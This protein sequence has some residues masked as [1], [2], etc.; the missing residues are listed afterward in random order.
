[1][2]IKSLRADYDLARMILK[3][4]LNPKDSNYYTGFGIYM[5]SKLLD[6]PPIHA[7]YLI[8]TLN[9]KEVFNEINN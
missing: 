3:K 7:Y 5:A 2:D 4:P 6:C 1:M 9:V 8:K